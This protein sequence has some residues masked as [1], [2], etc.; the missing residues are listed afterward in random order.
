VV[1]DALMQPSEVREMRKGQECLV[2]V[3]L[4]LPIKARYLPFGASCPR[5]G[6]LVELGQKFLRS[7]AA[8]ERRQRVKSLT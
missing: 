7:V 6:I 3:D 8:L 1:R 5:K 4:L 2:A